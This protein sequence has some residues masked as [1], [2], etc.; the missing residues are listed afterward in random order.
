MVD[1]MG[2]IH[3]GYNVIMNGEYNGIINGGYNNNLPEALRMIQSIEKFKS[4]LK[5]YLFRQAYG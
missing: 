2:I 3:G 5:T 4:H 1:I